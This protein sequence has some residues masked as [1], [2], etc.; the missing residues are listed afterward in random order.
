MM[1]QLFRNRLFG[2]V[3]DGAGRPYP[4]YMPPKRAAM[5]RYGVR[6]G[7]VLWRH[8]LPPPI[9]RTTLCNLASVVASRCARFRYR[10]R[11]AF[12]GHRALADICARVALMLFLQAFTVSFS[13][14]G[15]SACRIVSRIRMR[16]NNFRDGCAVARG[17]VEFARVGATAMEVN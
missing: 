16:N 6:T 15:C 10:R 1:R 11:R 12:V 17:Y 5:P 14:G 7:S 3:G 2:W 8:A 9:I 13:G 4:L